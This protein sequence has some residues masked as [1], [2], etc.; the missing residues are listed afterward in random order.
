MFKPI[1]EDMAQVGAT[2]FRLYPKPWFYPT[3]GGIYAPIDESHVELTGIIAQ[4]EYA[5]KLRGIRGVEFRK[6]TALSN[7]PKDN[8]LLLLGPNGERLEITLI[9]L[10]IV[11]EYSISIFGRCRL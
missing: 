9:S 7:V 4:A 8:F 2:A 3:S 10:M 5:K 11:L 6:D 1:A